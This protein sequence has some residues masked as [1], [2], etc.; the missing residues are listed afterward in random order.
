MLKLMEDAYSEVVHWEKNAFTV[1]FDNT[2]EEFVLQ[3]SR[4]LRAYADGTAL[5]SIAL[6]ANT[7]LS[8]LLLYEHFYY[9]KPKDHLAC[10]DR[11]LLSWKKGDIAELL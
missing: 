11:C 3:L 9:L 4:L 6:M 7:V 5:E 10:L 1:P 8:V 2:G